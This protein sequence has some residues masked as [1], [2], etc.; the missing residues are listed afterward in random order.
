MSDVIVYD[1]ATHYIG[2]LDDGENDGWWR[3]PARQDGWTQRK[4]CPAPDPDDLYEYGA[5]QAQ[6]ALKLSGAET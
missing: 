5:D 1:D 3:W 6:L 2:Y 4:V